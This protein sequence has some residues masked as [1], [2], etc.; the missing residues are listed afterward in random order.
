M[1]TWTNA[2]SKTSRRPM[3]AVTRRPISSPALGSG[4][5]PFDWPD[6]PMPDP[7]G[8]DRVPA[9][10]SRA[11][12]TSAVGLT[13]GISGRIGR[14]SSASAAL[15]S[16]LANKLRARLPTGGSIVF[17]M[18]WKRSHTPAGRPYCRLQASARSTNASGYG[19]WPTPCQQDGPKGGPNQGVDR[20]PTA[21]TLATWVPPTDDSNRGGAQDAMQ[22]IAGGHTV[23]LQDQVLLASWPTPMAGDTMNGRKT[24]LL[25]T[26]WPTPNTPSGGRS[27]SIES[28]DATGRTKDGKKHTASLE[29]AVKFA[30]WVSPQAADARGAGMNQHT[31][32]LCQQARGQ[33]SAGI[34]AATGNPGRLNPAFSLWL[35]LGT[36]ETVVAWLSAAPSNKPSPRY[37]RKSPRTSSTASAPCAAR[38]MPSTRTS[39]RRSSGRIVTPEKAK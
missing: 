13:I 9:S 4:R 3:S 34:S 16:C 20:L 2:T 6:G 26:G 38:A 11:R 31:S 36:V 14:G 32:S 30:S 25:V 24:R 22:R 1:A 12:A 17:R 33:M 7:S 19:L 39:R 37:H 29:H 18:T 35:L 5:L 10:R 15:Q 23:N 21:A 27:V 8:P 28:M